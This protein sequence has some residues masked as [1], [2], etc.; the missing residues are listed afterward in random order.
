METK[1]YDPQ[2]LH[3][4]DFLWKSMSRKETEEQDSQE[5][6]WLLWLA[7]IAVLSALI[8]VL[9]DKEP[10]RIDDNAPPEAPGFYN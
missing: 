5:R 6:F 8:W 1:P 7:V 3:D 2:I 9:S 4:D 10:S